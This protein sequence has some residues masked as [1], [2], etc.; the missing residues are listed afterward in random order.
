MCCC[1]QGS[2]RIYTRALFASRSLRGELWFSF[3]G[4]GAMLGLGGNLGVGVFSELSGF[5]SCA[6]IRV[7]V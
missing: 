1:Q 7:R 2:S 6:P 3:F 4:E 5:H